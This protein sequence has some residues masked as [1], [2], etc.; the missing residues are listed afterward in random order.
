MGHARLPSAVNGLITVEFDQRT[1]AEAS[2]L[3]VVEDRGL[4]SR[5]G[6]DLAF[7]MVRDEP[8]V[9]DSIVLVGRGSE[10]GSS[11]SG[12][13]ALR[14]PL[15]AI[16]PEAD[17]A[18]GATTDSEALARRAGWVYVVGS[19]FGSDRHGLQAERAFVA[20]FQEGD[21]DVGASPAAME[22]IKDD[23]RVHRLVN[24][25]LQDSGVLPSETTSLGR[26]L[27]HRRK[28]FIETTREH[29][30]GKAWAERLSKHDWPINIEGATFHPD[31]SLILGLR[32][33]VAS[34]GHPV[35]VR[36]DGVERLFAN[37][38]PAVREVVVLDD[39]GTEWAPI[40]VRDV[41]AT[42][43]SV[44]VLVGNLDKEMFDDYT[45]KP[46]FAH[47]QTHLTALG[48][49]RADRVTRVREFPRKLGRIEGLAVGPG[50]QV[51]Y[52]CDDED[53][54]RLL[55]ERDGS[56]VSSSQRRL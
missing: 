5:R 56:P 32:F 13:E 55:F 12:W 30:R 37:G 54:V 33:P 9:E 16:G 3:V 50:G 53:C 17:R 26:E 48:G 11:R 39:I 43:E 24:D 23:F 42:D 29:A 41:E 28:A 4:L 34:G 2:A 36:V 14:V 51:F 20:R 10:Q 46:R 47:W 45:E 35:L 15:E 18:H 52:V 8:A 25:A 21:V 6:W 7:W 38:A 19:H 49:D 27:E 22:V 1:L 40:G 31:G 44:H